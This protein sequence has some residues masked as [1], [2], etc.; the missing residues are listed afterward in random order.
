MV[1]R[2]DQLTAQGPAGLRIGIMRV[3]HFLPVPVQGLHGAPLQRCAR[4]AF[5]VIQKKATGAGCL[6][7]RNQADRAFQSGIGTESVA[8]AVALA[9]GHDAQQL[10]Y[11]PV[12]GGGSVKHR[13]AWVGLTLDRLGFGPAAA[14]FGVSHHG[15]QVHHGFRALRAVH[16]DDVDVLI[17]Q[18]V[19]AGSQTAT[20]A[21]RQCGSLAVGAV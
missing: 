7:Q 19:A 3:D 12:R 2:I 11:L 14:D 5:A 10:Q 13:L 8:V 9:T 6:L 15:F 1:V 18:I 16:G 4:V 17:G 21:R 20:F